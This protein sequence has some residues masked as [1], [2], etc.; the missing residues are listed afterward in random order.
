[1]RPLD[2]LRRNWRA[3]LAVVA[4]LGGLA[5][6]WAVRAAPLQPAPFVRVDALG[7][8]FSFALLG[9]IALAAL[10][11]PGAL[12]WRAPAGVALLLIAWNTTLTP[13]I[14]GMYLLLALSEVRRPTLRLRSGQATDP[15]LPLR[16]GDRRP[17]SEA[18]EPRTENRELQNRRT[19]ELK[20]PTPNSQL[21]TLND[22]RTNGG[23][24]WT[25][26]RVGSAIRRGLRVAPNLVAA[27]A[28]LV[29][30][31]AL[32]AR[33]GLLYDARTAGAALD[34]FVFWFVLLAAAAPIS[35]LAKSSQAKNR[36]PRTEN[37]GWES[38]ERRVTSDANDTRL[39][40]RDTA[41]SFTRSPAHSLT[42]IFQFAWLYPLARL[43]SL[44][45]WNTGWSFA[46]LLLG[47]AA[48][49]W[50]ALAALTRPAD[51]GVL[52]PRCFLALA[53]AGL[54]LGTGAGIAA[55][56]Y[57]V[58]AYLVLVLPTLT[59]DHRPPTDDYRPPEDQETRRQGEEETPNYGLRTKHASGITHHVSRNIHWLLS[60]A[61]PITAPFV[62]AWMLVGASVA[63]G[64]ALLAGV[65]W[66]VVLLSGLTAALVGAEAEANPRSRLFAAVA[67]VALGVG[68]PLIVLLLIQPVIEQLQGG[69][70]L[71]GDVNIWPW[72]GLAAIDAG[73]TP[74]TTLPSIAVAAFML[75][76]C[77]LVYLIARLRG[78]WAPV[79]TSGGAPTPSLGTLLASLRDEVPWLGALA[80]QPADE[81]PSVDS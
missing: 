69:L 46:T 59:T 36:E 11:W 64:V 50:V 73:H 38:D 26:Q 41:L 45:P 22:E 80:P 70:T 10:A 67:S 49:L 56:C 16:A 60:G 52:A 40:T 48:A 2:R 37:Q 58:L 43:Y 51:R 5:L 79:A 18:L 62:A 44:G 34:S 57:G 54:G 78:L 42:D 71:Y 23:N 27:G 24:R 39:T 32:A 8:F 65:A 63:G 13:A 35:I 28:L 7:A 3:L 33:G 4:A 55:G 66:L 72:V 81:E 53:L 68:A 74:V 30:Y 17:I 14:V 9:G 20:S 75:V 19:A 6:M 21:P 25:I 15:S 12:G 29:G 61:I 76:L 1:M 31:G 77:A 47:G